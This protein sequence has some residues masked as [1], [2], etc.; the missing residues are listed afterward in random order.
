MT[1]ALDR[2]ATG[3]YRYRQTPAAT[4]PECG[5]IPPAIC[6]VKSDTPQ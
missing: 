4:A 2:P 1:A 3:S 6:G 5:L